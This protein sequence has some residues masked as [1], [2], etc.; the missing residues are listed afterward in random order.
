MVTDRSVPDGFDADA[1][2][3]R[4]GDL[5]DELATTLPGDVFAGSASSRSS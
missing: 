5:L 2:G 1:I 4:I 3:V